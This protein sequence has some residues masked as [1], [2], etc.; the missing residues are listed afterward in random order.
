MKASS[1]AR[2]ICAQ[3]LL[4]VV[5][6]EN[7]LLAYVPTWEVDSPI[8]ELREGVVHSSTIPALSELE[9]VTVDQQTV[10]LAKSHW[11]R[12]PEWTGSS[13]VVLRLS[14][15]LERVGEIPLTET[16]ARDPARVIY[17]LSA[18]EVADDGLR[19]RGRRSVRKRASNDEIE[20]AAVDERWGIGEG[21]KLVKR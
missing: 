12:A 11:I 6:S 21:G 8:A 4:R 1:Y 9:V 13:L 5:A 2:A 17:A 14:P 15:P 10:V 3:Q 20:G 19:V 16:D 7:T 18:L